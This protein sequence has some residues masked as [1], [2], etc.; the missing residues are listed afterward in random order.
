M[1]ESLN[2]FSVKALTNSGEMRDLEITSISEET[3]ALEL[4][5]AGLTPLSITANT[6]NWLDLLNRPIKFDTKPNLANLA[7]FT[8]QLAEMLKAGLTVERA[9]T[10]LA[11]QH[12]SKTMTEL[13][14]RL[15]RRLSEGSTLSNA[16]EAEAYLPRYLIGI[17][18]ASEQG[19]RMS[20]GLTDA[21]RYLQRQMLTRRGVINALTYPAVVFVMI[22][23]SLTFVLGFVIPEFES[24]FAGEEHRLP[25]ITRLV[26]TLSHL[27]T[28]QGFQLLVTLIGVPVLLWISIQKSVKFKVFIRKA[29]L[30]I[31]FFRLITYVDIANVLGV[32]GALIDNGVEVS[33]SVQFAAQAASTQHIREPL[34][35]VSRMLREGVSVSLALRRTNLIPETTLSIIEVGEHTGS[36]G[37]A[38][39]RAAQLLETDSMYKIDRLITLLNPIAIALLGLIVGAVISGVMLGIMSINQLAVK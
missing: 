10:I 28:E 34:Q 18:R 25:K 23:I 26:L 32:M 8:E 9:L 30:R 5:R 33:E 6:S 35:H 17:V 14:S 21:T 2:K 29:G 3:V 27:V 39:M 16:M 38:T 36:L 4:L 24:I 20:E 19:G 1:A 31:S 12:N 7:M 11:K 22:V 15:L 37:T 13:V